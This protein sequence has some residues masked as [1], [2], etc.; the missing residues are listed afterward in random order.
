V[1]Y[2]I[3]TGFTTFNEMQ[4]SCGQKYRIGD[5]NGKQNTLLVLLPKRPLMLDVS[6]DKFG[7]FIIDWRDFPLVQLLILQSIIGIENTRAI[8]NQLQN[9]L[10]IAFSKL[11]FY[12]NNTLINETDCEK[13][14]G[15]KTFFYQFSWMVLIN[16]K[17]PKFICPTI[18]TNSKMN[19]LEVNDISDSLI[20]RNKFN[21]I[22]F[23]NERVTI[24]KNNIKEVVFEV[25]YEHL[26]E[27]LFNKHMFR[28]VEKLSIKGVLHSIEPNL[29]KD[30]NLSILKL[31]IENLKD[32]FHRDTSWMQ[33]LM[34]KS[35]K[36]Q[37]K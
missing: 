18:F 31:D 16:V 21:V 23:N 36:C 17:F 27:R 32:F 25:A 30:F 1:K 6:F 34:I 7:F 14:V 9:T 11:D 19:S 15:A 8:N 26:T 24:K 29:F 10:L 5:T 28:G 33:S 37:E 20:K 35:K 4:M 12:L 13:L 2:T 22:N 3:F